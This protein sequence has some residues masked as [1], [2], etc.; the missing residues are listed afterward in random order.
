MYIEINISHPDSK[1]VYSN[2]YCQIVQFSSKNNTESLR[3][4]NFF[5]SSTN[6][7]YNTKTE[8]QSKILSD[9]NLFSV[10]K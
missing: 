3:P 5:V 8:G 9:L 4:S 10:Y 1:G 2:A 6:F 7:S